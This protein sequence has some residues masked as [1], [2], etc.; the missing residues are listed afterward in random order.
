M[1]CKKHPKYKGI[2][3]PRVKC[4]ECEHIYY[5]KQNPGFRGCLGRVKEL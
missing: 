2:R 5:M 4:A 1:K 3:K